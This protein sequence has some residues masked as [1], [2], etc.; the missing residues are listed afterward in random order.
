MAGYQLMKIVMGTGLSY[1]TLKALSKLKNKVQLKFSTLCQAI[2]QQSIQR[3]VKR[4]ICEIS[5]SG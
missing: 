5:V 1:N 2:T 3:K 4:F